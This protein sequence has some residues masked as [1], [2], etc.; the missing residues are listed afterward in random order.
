MIIKLLKSRINHFKKF[1]PYK[2]CSLW[3]KIRA[4]LRAALIKFFNRFFY[5]DV[6]LLSYM[7]K[8]YA[9][10]NNR[11][12][13]TGYYDSRNGYWELWESKSRHTKE[14]IEEFYNE[15]EHDVWRQVYLSEYDREKKNHVLRVYDL[16]HHFFKDKNIKIIDYGCGCGA[17]GHYLYKKGY[18]NIT[19]ADIESGT[20]EFTKKA[21]GSN[22]KYIEI[23]SDMSLEENYDIIMLIDCLAHAFNPFEVIKHVIDHL[24]KGGFL[25]VFFEK[26]IQGTHL[27]SASN[28]RE[29]VM[30]YIYSKC[31]CLKEDEIFVKT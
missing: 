31:R 5:P 2:D 8:L 10:K 4:I 22:F 19:L 28:Q 24:K 1:Y 16:I 6:S 11:E 3:F 7:K 23:N 27:A 17:Y 14:A 20:F 30:N 13:L 26:G 21:F 29:K 15:Q 12:F 18:K 9:L 25:V